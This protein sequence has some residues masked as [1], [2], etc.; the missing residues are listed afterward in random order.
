V[1]PWKLSVRFD[2]F[3]LNDVLSECES[4]YNGL[5]SASDSDSDSAAMISAVILSTVA[6]IQGLQQYASEGGL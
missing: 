1:D 2:R 4:V 3:V 5:V 6:T